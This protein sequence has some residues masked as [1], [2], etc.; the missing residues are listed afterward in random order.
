MTDR[1]NTDGKWTL[2]YSWSQTYPH[3]SLTFGAMNRAATLEA[4]LDR[5]AMVDRWVDA[6]LTYPDAERIINTIREKI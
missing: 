3:P 5:L 1:Q 4:E 6:M 2:N